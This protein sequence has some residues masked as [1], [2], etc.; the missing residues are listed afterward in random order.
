MRSAAVVV[1]T[2]FL[3]PGTVV[4]Q[5]SQ[6]LGRRTA[7]PV[8]L[9]LPRM[10][11]LSVDQP[12]EI[13]FTL[14]ARHKGTSGPWSRAGGGAGA[15]ARVGTVA[16][17]LVGLAMGPALFHGR[18]MGCDDIECY[19]TINSAESYLAGAAVGAGVGYLLGHF[20]G[21]ATDLDTGFLS[22]MRIKVSPRGKPGLK[23]KTTIRF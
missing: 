14:E 16:G 10:A 3:F 9:A 20:L 17:W 15:G 5:G 1:L 18:D 8:S 23:V 21:L 13:T 4:G 19:G 6:A 22:G 12:G 2:L 7:F 11:D